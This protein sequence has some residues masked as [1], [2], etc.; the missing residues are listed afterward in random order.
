MVI[1]KIRVTYVNYKEVQ[2][3]LIEA[4]PVRLFLMKKTSGSQS[5]GLNEDETM[6]LGDGCSTRKLASTIVTPSRDLTMNVTQRTRDIT[7]IL[8]FTSLNDHER[9][10]ETGEDQMIDALEDME[11]GEHQVGEKMKCEVEDD[12]L[13]GM[14]L[15]EM[16]DNVFQHDQ[17]KARAR[18]ENKV[19]KSS[20]R[21]PIS[22]AS[23]GFPSKKIEI[24]RRGS[25]R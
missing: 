11:A 7:R 17:G 8:S 4:C 24:L 22:T 23:L 13:L 2:C 6:R 20:R 16:E 18:S 10:M 25:P 21:G 9:P 3:N 12:V 14:E 1:R 5:N 15:R 19:Q